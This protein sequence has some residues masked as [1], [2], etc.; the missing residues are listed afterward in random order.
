M[1]YNIPGYEGFYK[2]TKNGAVYSLRKKGWLKPGIGIRKGRNNVPGRST[3]YVILSTCPSDRKTFNVAKLVALTF[4]PN[5]HNYPQINHIDGNTLNNQVGNL[6]W[7]T[8]SHNIKHAYDNG[9]MKPQRGK[10]KNTKGEQNIH[11]TRNGKWAV[12][13][14]HQSKPYSVGTYSNIEDAKVARDN[15]INSLSEH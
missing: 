15:F 11:K 12:Q 10:R 6:E 14:W 9:F 7:C 13:V 8:Q 5:P 1:L 2:I 4:L 3:A